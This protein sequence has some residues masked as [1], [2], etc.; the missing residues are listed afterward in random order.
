[1]SSR[2][3]S[4]SPY[5][6]HAT[7]LALVPTVA[8]NTG[9]VVLLALIAAPAVKVDLVPLELSLA[10]VVLVLAVL[11]QYL[12]V[13][14][15]VL[16]QYLVVAV[17]VVRRPNVAVNMDIAVLLAI[18][19]GQVVKVDL[20]PLE[21]VVQALLVRLLVVLVDNLVVMQH[22]MLLDWEAVVGRTR[23]LTI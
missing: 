6:N 18:I 5:P 19:V 12:V 23:P 1:M 15:A 3:F 13:V 21:V 9:T 7:L 14:A 11:A 8:A 17:V 4:S 2:P 20:V 16:A 10:L 22:G